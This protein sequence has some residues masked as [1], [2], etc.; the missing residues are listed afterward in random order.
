MADTIDD[1]A[2]SIRTDGGGS[3]KPPR[4][5]RGPRRPDDG[6]DGRRKVLAEI[7]TVLNRST[8]G[9]LERLAATDARVDRL[10]AHG[11]MLLRNLH[12][13]VDRLNVLERRVAELEVQLASRERTDKNEG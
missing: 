1:L 10:E 13:V 5:P 8:T 6:D 12:L 2:R 4:P 7:E 3:G 11:D 9:L